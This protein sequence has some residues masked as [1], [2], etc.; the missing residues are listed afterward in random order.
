MHVKRKQFIL[1]WNNDYRRYWEVDFIK[2]WKLRDEEQKQKWG[3]SGFSLYG[4]RPF[5]RNSEKGE[6]FKVDLIE[7]SSFHGERISVFYDRTSRTLVDDTKVTEP[8]PEAGSSMLVC[9]YQIAQTYRKEWK[10]RVDKGEKLQKTRHRR[11]QKITKLSGTR[12]NP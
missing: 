5:C 1:G 2:S 9:T 7:I 3:V 12:G 8:T 4:H 11:Q 10:V 6:K